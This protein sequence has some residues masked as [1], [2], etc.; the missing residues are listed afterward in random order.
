MSVDALS[1]ACNIITLIDFSH[2]FYETYRDISD[3]RKPDIDAQQSATELSELITKLK[4]SRKN[5]SLPKNDQ[6]DRVADQCLD[7]ATRLQTEMGKI[8]PS[9]SSSR[10][11]QRL[12]NLVSTGRRIWRHDRVE[13]MK[14]T[15]ETCQRTMQDVVLVEM[16]DSGRAEQLMRRDEFAKLETRLQNFVQAL[17]ENRL[18]VSDL[19]AE[20][21][22]LHK[23]TRDVV[24]KEILALRDAQVSDAELSR[25]KASLKFPMINQRYNDVRPGHTKSFRWLFGEGM[26]SNADT[27][28]HPEW[29]KSHL[30]KLRG[31]TFGDFDQ[32][33]KSE[34]SSDLYWISGK[35][36]AGKST[37]MKYLCRQMEDRK[38]VD[39]P[40]VVIHHFFWLG[41][42]RSQSRQNDL[43]GM[44]STLLFQLSAVK[45]DP[46]TTLAAILLRQSPHLG[47]MDTY[48]DWSLEE[49]RTT[50]R[51][52]LA[53]L[54][55]QYFIYILLDALDEH[56]PAADHEELLMIIKELEDAPGVRIIAS[57]RRE[58]IFERYLSHSRQLRLQDLTAADIHSF[59]ADSLRPK[60]KAAF[61]EDTSRKLLQDI[62]DT[63]VTKAQGVFLW[64]RLAVDSVKRGL[65]DRNSED[66][67]QK[68]LNDLP[69]SLSDYFK[70]IWK[71]LGDDKKIYQ[72]KAANIF[73]LLLCDS[74]N[75]K[76][77]LCQ[78]LWPLRRT[79]KSLDPDITCLSFALM[80]PQDACSFIQG[81][82]IIRRSKLL[83]LRWHTQDMILSHCAGLVELTPPDV[84]GSELQTPGPEGGCRFIH[85]TVADFLREEGKDIVN[86]NN[87]G[88]TGPDFRLML[89]F[90]A[91]CVAF[92]EP[93]YDKRM[94]NFL[95]DI[96][97]EIWFQ[98]AL[99]E[100]GVGSHLT[101]DQRLSLLAM[102]HTIH[103]QFC[104]HPENPRFTEWKLAYCWDSIHPFVAK[105]AY[106]GHFD[107]VMHWIKE[108]ANSESEL[109]PEALNAILKAS[110][111]GYF[112]RFYGLL[113]GSR[114]AEDLA[115]QY[116]KSR[117]PQFL[118]DLRI[119]WTY[120]DNLNSRLSRYCLPP[121]GHRDTI[122]FHQPRHLYSTTQLVLGGFLTYFDGFY[123]WGSEWP[124]SKFIKAYEICADHVS[125]LLKLL[126]KLNPQVCERT[127][128][129][130]RGHI[131]QIKDKYKRT[132]FIHFGR[133]RTKEPYRMTSIHEVEIVL[134]VS[135]LWVIWWLAQILK[136]RN[137]TDKIAHMCLE[138]V[139]CAVQGGQEIGIPRPI[140][141]LGSKM[142]VMSRPHCWDSEICPD[143]M[144]RIPLAIADYLGEP[145]RARISS[146]QQLDECH[147][148]L[149]KRVEEAWSDASVE[150]LEGEQRDKELVDRGIWCS[151]EEMERTAKACNIRIPYEASTGRSTPGSGP[152]RIIVPPNGCS[153]E[154]EAFSFVTMMF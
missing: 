43:V 140:L 133:I 30:R 34:S 137:P 44:F 100:A 116:M 11:H 125:Q 111:M 142:P 51:M 117:L 13:Q 103:Y 33:L 62:V 139:N 17:A 22:T 16:Y 27:T 66:E 147:V 74:W 75:S 10:I 49:L 7:A 94:H 136:I 99:P 85:R 15:L 144:R 135:L 119:L 26:I 1:L 96:E 106:Y 48:T 68:R 82:N 28:W 143:E 6:L 41:T 148:T 141:L 60:I 46:G 153:E 25:F 63:I 71:R 93:G 89:A 31:K 128:C 151:T 65:I 23:E 79:S 39:K 130:Y 129:I 152:D 73:S 146:V 77:P 67:L 87:F 149:G 2:K 47:E 20:N 105:A 38:I 131:Y 3:N 64:A 114:A 88:D 86:S 121:Q 122:R 54:S 90:L 107:Y 52:A 72:T 50:I 58:P 37:L 110:L 70:S 109:S 112:P 21:R 78:V 81:D 84:V 120:A 118:K 18:Q 115:E 83:E 8:T 4:D 42:S 14:K 9:N 134:E 127:T 56:L 40:Y 150:L 154:E 61:A 76:S 5:A 145:L 124:D 36:G 138:V 113:Q 24:R 91:R 59:A 12:H 19:L 102:Y 57:S 97:P 104:G 126:T 35:P 101:A 92:R 123:N 108:N 98:N 132:R 53:T 80:P 95:I 55:G 32:W 69:S 45:V 29:K